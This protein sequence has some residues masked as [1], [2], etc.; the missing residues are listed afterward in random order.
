VTPTD[1]ARALY[2]AFAAGDG[3]RLGELLGA[4]RWTE[5]AG[6]PYGGRYEGLG[7]VAANVFGPIARDIEGFSARP[8]EFLAVGNDRVL[9]LGHYGGTG[10]GGALNARFAH[11]LTVADGRVTHFEQIA[12]THSFRQAIG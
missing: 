4:T 1:T 9:A 10:A 5:C 7:E 6:M 11:L 3:A 2:E 8:D 12:D